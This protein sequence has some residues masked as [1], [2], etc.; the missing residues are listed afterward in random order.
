MNRTFRSAVTIA[1]LGL[2]ARTA[3][4][5]TTTTSKTRA[6]GDSEG[7]QLLRGLNT[8]GIRYPLRIAISDSA[9]LKRWWQ[10]AR[11]RASDT[12]SAPTVD[13]S[14]HT[15]V[16]I[17]IG[18]VWGIGVRVARVDSIGGVVSIH[19][20]LSQP[21]AG[22]TLAAEMSAPV[23]FIQVTKTIGTIAY[24][25]RVTHYHCSGGTPR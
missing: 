12:V 10:L 17:G 25:D 18:E 19:V 21:E 22:C 2:S 6:A 14:K 20:E 15:V 23:Q 4:A 13:F 11:I 9:A 1:L 8:S 24:D 5:Q 16:L 7:F 3:I